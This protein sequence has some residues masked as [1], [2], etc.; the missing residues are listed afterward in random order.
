MRYSVD[1]GALDF[2]PRTTKMVLTAKIFKNAG[3]SGTAEQAA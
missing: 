2:H 3:T 1:L